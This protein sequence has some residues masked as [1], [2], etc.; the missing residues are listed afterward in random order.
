MLLVQMLY[1][2]DL[3][4]GA[5]EGNRQGRLVFVVMASRGVSDCGRVLLNACAPSE[6]SAVLEGLLRV[7][8]APC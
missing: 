5:G 6:S 1:S 7:P 8:S 2:T 4:D 3:S